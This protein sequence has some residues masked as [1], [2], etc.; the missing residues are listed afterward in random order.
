[1]M[2]VKN[3][4]RIRVDT[5]IDVLATAVGEYAK[6]FGATVGCMDSIRKGI[7]EHQIIEQIGLNYFAGN[8]LVGQITMKIDWD[9]HRVQVESEKGNEIQLNADQTVLEQLDGAS[10]EIIRHVQRLRIKCNVT[11]IESTFRYR[12]EY[13]CNEQKHEDARRYLGHTQAIENWPKEQT[14]EFKTY[15]RLIMD[16]L[17]ELEVTIEN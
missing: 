10:Q 16:K 5:R 11:R 13:L 17:R 1:M 3:K 4:N 15:I 14:T 12:R 7:L 6:A 2:S 8:R 9:Y